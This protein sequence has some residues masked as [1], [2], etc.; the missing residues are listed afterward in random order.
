MNQHVIE[1]N[2]G[3]VEA[4]Q[5]GVGWWYLHRQRF[6]ASGKLRQVKAP[7]FIGGVIAIGPY[8]QEDAEFMAEHMVN[9]GG[10]PASAVKVKKLKVAA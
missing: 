10:M 4:S 9:S 3:V 2:E 7:C 6:V 8:D 5:Q 1:V